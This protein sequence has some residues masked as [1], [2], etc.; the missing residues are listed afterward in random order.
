MGHCTRKADSDL[1]VCEDDEHMKS[2]ELQ[3]E[4]QAHRSCGEPRRADRTERNFSE[5][6]ITAKYGVI[7]VTTLVPYEVAAPLGVDGMGEVY[8][9]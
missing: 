2:L 4:C 6:V 7:P 8:R 1:S 3:K 5:S 9:P